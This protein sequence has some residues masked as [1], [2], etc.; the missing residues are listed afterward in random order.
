MLS[1]KKVVEARPGVLL[2][3]QA[4][5]SRTTSTVSTPLVASATKLGMAVSV[6]KCY[7]RRFLSPAAGSSQGLGYP[8]SVRLRAHVLCVREHSSSSQAAFSPA[9]PKVKG[10][11][12]DAHR[13]SPE[14]HWHM[15][16]EP[17]I[18][19]PSGSHGTPD[20]PRSTPAPESSGLRMSIHGERAHSPPPPPPRP[21]QPP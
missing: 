1:K 14:A 6:A 16:S 19:V 18:G 11:H 10:G 5:K 13:H 9:Q 15:A 21:P 20:R 7:H 8:A 17:R 2:P 3:T 12:V 4:G